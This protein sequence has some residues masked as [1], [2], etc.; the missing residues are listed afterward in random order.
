MNEEQWDELREEDRR[1]QIDP[2]SF[3]DIW[4]EHG[5]ANAN[6]YYQWRGC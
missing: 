4:E 3:G 2:E 1:E 6:D 5:F